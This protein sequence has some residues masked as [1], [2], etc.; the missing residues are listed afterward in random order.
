MENTLSNYPQYKAALDTEIGKAAESFVKTG[1]LLRY[2]KEHPEVL[3]GSGYANINEMAEK[4]YSIDASQVSRF[5]AINERFSA[6]GYS[7]RLEAKWEGFGVAKLGIMLQLPDN[8]NKELSPD[9]TKTEINTLKDEVKEEQKVTDME[10]L[11]EPKPEGSPLENALK[12]MVRDSALYKTLAELPESKR[13]QDGIKEVLAPAGVSIRTV[14]I[15]GTGKVMIKI[16]ES[17]IV[18]LIYV[19]TNETGEYPF[20][21]AV[22]I[23]DDLVMQ[24][25]SYEAGYKQLFGEDYPKDDPLVEKVA[26]TENCTGAKVTKTP[27]KKEPEKKE[28]KNENPRRENAASE[29]PKMPEEETEI[30]P[31]PEPAQKTEDK[32]L[33][34]ADKVYGENAISEGKEPQEILGQQRYD[35]LHIYRR[36]EEL[37]NP[38]VKWLLKEAS[39]DYLLEFKDKLQ[40]I[41]RDI[42]EIIS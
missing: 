23:L 26:K 7:E 19:R 3:A 4:E 5:I 25:G 28:Q 8:L 29:V 38:T 22:Q 9:F 42:E 41:I 11:L 17:D 34:K 24:N 27:V 37:A 14:R 20:G 33:E 39:K 18:K 30:L 21:S 2:A 32:N 36:I 13:T 12:E 1:Y 10:V 16:D 40:S 6:G 15:P 35:A 31:P